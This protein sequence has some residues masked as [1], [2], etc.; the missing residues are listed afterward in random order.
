VKVAI[1]YNKKQL[2]VSDVINLFGPQTKERYNPNTVE[3]VAKALEKGGHN[4]KVIDG[5][6]NVVDELRSFMPRVVAGEHPGMVFNMAYGMQGQSRYTHIPA[7]LEM[8]GV[9]YVGS[10]PQGHA[11]ALDKVMSK[12]VFQAHSLP[13]PR[14]WVFSN[15]D[16][17]Q[18]DLP[19]PLIVKPRMEAVSLGLRVV[20]NRIELHE[21]VR[22]II[23]E[24]QQQALVEEF[25]PGR[26]F[27]VGLLGNGRNLEVFPV[28]EIDLGGDP[29][30]IQS[31]EDKMQRP[32]EKVCPAD[33]PSEVTAEMK[34]V[35][36]ESF[37]ALGLFDFSR[38]DLRMD[39]EGHISI[40]E[41]NSMASLGLTGSYVHAAKVAGYTYESLTNRMLDVAAIR[42]FGESHMPA[43]SAS[44]TKPEQP[45]PLRVRVRSYLRSH[46]TTMEDYLRQM[47]EMNTYV[48]NIE[49]VN[50]LGN[51]MSNRLAQ[52]G[53][54][55]HVYP[56]AEVGN[57][58][59]FTNH[60]D[61][62]NDILLLGHLDIPYSY[63]DYIPFREE[64]G[65]LYGS[66][67]AESKG[68]LAVLLGT[69]QALRF[70]RRLKRVRCGILL[71]TDDS[72]GG[73]FSRKL[74]E[75]MARRSKYVVGLK[76]GDTG[77]GIVTSCSG[78]AHY[79]IEITNVKGSKAADTPD[80]FA[81]LCQKVRAWQR[82]SSPEQ[83]ISVTVTSLEGRTRYGRTPDHAAIS[84]TARFKDKDQGP[85]LAQEIRRIAQRGAATK[86]QVRVRSGVRRPPITET[87]AIRQ[88]F[89]RVQTLANR[90]EVRAQPIHRNTSSDISYVPDYIPALDGLGPV[91]SAARSPNEYILRDSL[92]DRAALLALVIRECLKEM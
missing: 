60:E 61:E 32:R 87:E 38:V 30:A 46:S 39:A 17:I 2:D 74:V 79:Q 59:Y 83:G 50:A 13:T 56:Q 49:E 25:I 92:I 34:R 58:L 18:D 27:A 75:E 21:A 14:F 7:M 68:G 12:I 70:A 78:A 31:I 35:A 19:Y 24:F 63:Q 62:Q 8:V 77:G 82:M 9:P 89:E 71:T 76:Y 65:R 42:Y 51:W 84:L 53:F 67:V 1:I 52:L 15:P 6:I 90:L 40:L 80:I 88:F 28:L 57:I 23:E 81:T 20:Y 45:E 41:I 4:V 64:R 26:E 85:A 86:L 54:Q 43:A 48:H 69:L 72:L 36:R 5:N 29:N 11:V 16:E 66:G 73:R 3:R 47:V 22:Y 33:V 55:R 10:G 44:E 37:R 91:G